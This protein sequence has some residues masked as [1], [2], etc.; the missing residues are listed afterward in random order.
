MVGMGS[1]DNIFKIV[2]NQNDLFCLIGKNFTVDW[3]VDSVLEKITRRIENRNPEKQTGIHLPVRN[4]DTPSWQLYPS[5]VSVS[6]NFYDFFPDECI[7]V[8]D[9]LME[10]K[11][12]IVDLN[13]NSTLV[14][15]FIRSESFNPR[16]MRLFEVSRRV[17]P[18]VDL[19]EFAVNIGLK[20]SSNAITTVSES[21]NPGNVYGMTHYR[22]QQQDGDVVILNTHHAHWVDPIDCN[23]KRYQIS[24]NLKFD[25]L[26]ITS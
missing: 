7:N 17:N 19:R 8:C 23:V 14:E 26:Q 11:K 4:D 21:K 2:M 5:G 25:P 6:H 3:N 20:N 12:T 24:Y 16:Y 13:L 15:Y 9:K 1:I 18:H 10:L 22:Y